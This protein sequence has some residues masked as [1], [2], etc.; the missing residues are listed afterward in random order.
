MRRHAGFTIIEVTIGLSLLALIL[1]GLVGALRGLGDVA[2]RLEHRSYLGDEFRITPAFLDKSLRR[3]NPRLRDA[4]PGAA[5]ANW[6]VG[7]RDRLEWVGVM[8]ARHGAGGL[9]HFR[10]FLDA[11][12]YGDTP[13]LLI[14]VAPFRGD[15]EA[16]DW[17][18]FPAETVI[19][20]VSSV[21]IRYRALGGDEWLG[22]WDHPQTLPG[23]VA[24]S[25]QGE[26]ASWPR[27]V[28]RLYEAEFATRG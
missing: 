10:I 18:R 12:V 2:S 20:A 7:E 17:S 28:F 5:R 22:R 27:L 9:S 21:E 23:W 24:I 16:P 26:K 3:A 14:Q 1:L 19:A 13:S 25:V 8:P 15:A 6:F 11:P 4:G